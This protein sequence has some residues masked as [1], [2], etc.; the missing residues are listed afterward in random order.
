MEV[1]EVGL[2]VFTIVRQQLKHTLQVYNLPCLCK[3]CP[4]MCHAVKIS[5]VH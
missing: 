4:H 3:I 2:K 1:I 5:F